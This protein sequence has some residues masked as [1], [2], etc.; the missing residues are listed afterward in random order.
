[1]TKNI[2]ECK[3]TDVTQH[4]NTIDYLTGAGAFSDEINSN[5]L[6]GYTFKEF[7]LKELGLPDYKEI[8][9]SVI[10]IKNEIGLAHWRTGNKVDHNYKGFSVT[11]NPDYFDKEVS[12]YHQT[13]GSKLLSQ[14]YAR[15]EGIGDHEFI[16]NT[17]YDSYGFRKVLPVV[18]KH[19]GY[20][21][22]RFSCPLIR[23]R[24]AFFNMFFKNPVD[25]GWH[26]DEI[27]TH[28]FRINIPLQT[29]EEY[30]L[31]IQ[32]QDEFGNSYSL[33]NKHLE[34]GKAYVW[35]TRIPHRVAINKFCQNSEDRIH[36][37]LGFSPWFDYNSE[38][39]SF[40][41]SKLYGTP[42]STIIND[43]PFLKPQ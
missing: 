3:L 20:V 18:D 43:R 12:A 21:L 9:D 26:I 6:Q 25:S 29:S 24:V 39:D 8:L 38:R 16:K 35:N 5:S 1:M 15:S 32:G 22:D 19:L 37:V 30:V 17:Y 14:S 33:K 13:W 40:I 7:S 41:S 23:S 36:L 42:L 11:H 34:V 28:L 2:F 31:D 4:Q 27:P 10:K